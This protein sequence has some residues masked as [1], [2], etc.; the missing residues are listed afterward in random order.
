MNRFADGPGDLRATTALVADLRRAQILHSETG[1]TLPAGT[2]PPP[3]AHARLSTDKKPNHREPHQRCGLLVG[4]F[5][6]LGS[7]CGQ[8]LKEESSAEGTASDLAAD[9]LRG[10][11]VTVLRETLRELFLVEACQG[12]TR[13]YQARSAIFPFRVQVV[14]RIS[15]V[16]K[17]VYICHI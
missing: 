15:H 3:R 2:P 7:E 11:R 13:P 14:R 4:N 9:A 17:T 8:D 1:V 16:L 6:C 12:Q 10:D 5:D